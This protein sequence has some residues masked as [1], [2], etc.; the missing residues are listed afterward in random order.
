MQPTRRTVLGGAAAAL[1]LAWAA[2][3]ASAAGTTAACVLDPH[4]DKTDLRGI[5]IASVTNI[6]WPSRP[7]LTPD[8]QKAELVSYYDLAVAKRYNAVVVQV[9][10]TADAF[11]PGALEPWS[12]YLTGAQGGDPGYD[13]LAFAVAEA[14]ARNLEFLLEV[15]PAEYR[16]RVRLLLEF[17]PHLERREVP[18]PY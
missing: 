5:W 17:A 7:G 2:P 9:R 1:A 14:H 10:P 3:N 13:P 6:D 12:K 8:Q 15:C 4:A 16:S 18:D 11:W